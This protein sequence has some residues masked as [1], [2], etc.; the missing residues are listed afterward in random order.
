LSYSD[1]SELDITSL[2]DV[3]CM[4]P[5]R[6]DHLIIRPSGRMSGVWSLRILE[7]KLESFLLIV[8][9]RRIFTAADTA[10]SAGFS[11]FPAY[12]QMRTASLPMRGAAIYLRTV[13]VT[14]AVYRGLDSQLRPKANLSS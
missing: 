1:T 10:S 11:E 4:S 12:G 2:D 9:T 7:P 8:R 3:H 6:G 13:I 14:A 5:C